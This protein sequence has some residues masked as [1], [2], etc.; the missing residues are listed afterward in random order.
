M[1][2]DDD[3]AFEAEMSALFQ[4]KHHFILDADN[5]AI[6]ATLLEWGRFRETDPRWR[7][8]HDAV[9]GLVVSTVFLGSDHNYAGVGPPILYET[10]VFHSAD[11]G[12]ADY[13]KSCDGSEARY[14]TYAEAQAGHAEVC[15]KI[16]RGEIKA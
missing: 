9:D 10:M 16:K 5:N 15:E 12:D 6:P 7:V 2:E 8:G 3:A 13:S 11:G 4:E 1:T 14:A